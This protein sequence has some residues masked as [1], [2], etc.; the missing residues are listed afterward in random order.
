MSCQKLRPLLLCASLLVLT[1]AFAVAQEEGE[2]IIAGPFGRPIALLDKQ[3]VWSAPISIYSDDDLE[4][5]IPDI[6]TP[7]WV[8]WWGPH[9]QRT[10]EYLV[11]IYTYYK[12]DHWCL[13]HLVPAAGHSTAEFAQSCK[14]VLYRRGYYKIDTRKKTVR[15]LED[16]W[17]TSTMLSLSQTGFGGRTAS[18]AELA[19]TPF[20]KKIDR[21][22]AIIED[23]TKSSA[24]LPNQ[25]QTEPHG[26]RVPAQIV[27]KGQTPG[28]V[29]TALGKPDA[30]VNLGT[31]MIYVYKH[32]AKI[33]FLNGKVSTVQ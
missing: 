31:K 9:F 26:D 17:M 22:T 15:I 20:G 2:M 33:T 10:G 4:T 13:T 19:G 7:G 18:F 21:I 23:E 11:D 12:N 3:G 6:T 25:P 29:Q 16:C 30:I 27:E 24:A 28:Q 32:L 14:A 1:C 8:Y 5:F